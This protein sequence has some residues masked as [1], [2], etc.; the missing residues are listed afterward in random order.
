MMGSL[1]YPLADGSEDD[2]FWYAEVGTLLAHELG[3]PFFHSF[4]NNDSFT[5]IS[6]HVKP[7]I[8]NTTNCYQDYNKRYPINHNITA[9]EI[10]ADNLGLHIAYQNAEIKWP[11]LEAL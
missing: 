10:M 7:K 8:R 11:D 6:P 4:L 2:V 1:G 5:L 3:H 9:G